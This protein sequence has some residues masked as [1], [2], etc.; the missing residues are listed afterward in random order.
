MGLLQGLSFVRP[1]AGALL[2]GIHWAAAGAHVGDGVLKL[3][4][5]LASVALLECRCQHK[6]VLAT[7]FVQRWRVGRG[8]RVLSSWRAAE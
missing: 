4:R 3:A 8:V 1:W 7:A 6:G 5:M 2:G